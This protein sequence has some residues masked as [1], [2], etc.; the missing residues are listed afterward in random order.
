M[1]LKRSKEEEF[2]VIQKALM[3]KEAAYVS[4]K[5]K[6]T[7]LEKTLKAHHISVQIERESTESSHIETMKVCILS[8]NILYIIIIPNICGA[9]LILFSMFKGTLHN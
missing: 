7:A 4:T 9:L 5:T 2:Q 6:C 3:E 1:Q 8:I